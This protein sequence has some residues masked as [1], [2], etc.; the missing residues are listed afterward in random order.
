MDWLLVKSFI[1]PFILTFFI[2][3]FVLVMQ[4]LWKYVD[5]LVG[6]G[7]STW[8]LSELLFYASARLVPLALPLAVLL[9]SIMTFGDLGEHMELTASKSAGI[10]LLRMMRPLLITVIFI[11]FFAF[12]FSNNVLP[13]ANLKFSALLYDIQHQKPTVAIK[14]GIFY[15]EIDGFNLR[16]GKKGSDGLTLYNILIYDHTSGQGDDHIVTAQKGQMTEDEK[17]MALTL[18]LENGEQYKELAPKA[19]D[20]QNYEMYHTSFGSWEKKFDLSRFKLTRTDENFFKDMKQMMTLTQL[21]HQID[22]I[23][24]DKKNLTKGLHNYVIPYYG[25]MRTGLDTLKTVPKTENVNFNTDF[26]N[27]ADMLRTYNKSEANSIMERALTQARNIKNYSNIVLKQMEFKD[28]D[29]IQHMVEVYRKFTLSI[30]CIVLFL[31]GAPLGSI[32][33]KGGLGWPLFWS[34][35]F[36]IIYHV[37]SIIGEKM[38]EK[39]IIGTF[40]GMWLST[41]I[42]LPIGAFLTYKAANDSP[43]FSA[44]FY[45][46][47][48]DRLRKSTRAV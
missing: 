18:M 47:L 37:T 21:T 29:I 27:T 17:G 16:V 35:L 45:L 3:L 2:A 48:T 33:R 23:N 22:T 7:L 4:F 6:K 34:V 8:V 20:K 31:I 43:L 13:M 1:G 32:I 41:F 25:Y 44:D 19:P 46:R 39:L 24:L 5:D 42:L 30:A 10:S 26:K 11:S 36:F 9:A 15:N 12:F 14:E 28:T 40:A 38:A